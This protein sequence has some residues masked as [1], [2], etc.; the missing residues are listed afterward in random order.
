MGRLI[1]GLV[2]GLAALVVTPPCFAQQAPPPLTLDAAE[3]LALAN[4]PQ[5]RAAEDLADAA[6]AAVREVRSA[7]YPFAV[8]NL[9]GA[10]ALS[11]S[12]IAAGALNN[13]VIYDRYANGITVGQLLTDFGRTGNLTGSADLRR[14]ALQETVMAARVEIQLRVAQTYFATLR[15]QAVAQVAEETVRAR[16]TVADQVTALAQNQLKSDLDVSFARVNLA[17][18]Q[19]L[20]VQAQNDVQASFA[21]LSTALGYPDQRIF[22]L[23]ESQPSVTPLAALDVLTAEALRIRPDVVSQRLDL[24][25]D[26]RFA[27][28]QADL[29]RPSVSFVASVGLTPF[30]QAA[31]SSRYAAAGVNVSVPLFNGHLF[32]ALRSEA[33]ARADAQRERVRDLENRVAHDVRIAWLHASAG[34]QRLDLTDQLAA[35]A[36][37]AFALAQSRYQLGLSSI[38]ELSQAQLNLT[39]AQIAQAAARYDYATELAVLRFQAGQTP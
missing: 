6:A 35:Q 26:Q 15:A 4:H 14:Q 17:Q 1:A 8:G 32:G 13:P 11:N 12:R 31:L 30:R 39:E 20:L 21:D 22:T 33:Q 10:A 16:Q 34:R 9:T 24:A 2:A 36:T 23:V 3:Q 29:W 7:Y 18:A 5:I 28:A 37:R 19:L 27:E 25:S 38:I